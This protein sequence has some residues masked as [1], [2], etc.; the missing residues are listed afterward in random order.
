MRRRVTCHPPTHSRSNSVVAPAS[1]PPAWLS[2][3]GLPGA[4]RGHRDWRLLDTAFGDGERFLQLWRAWSQDSQACHHLHVVAFSDSVPTADALVRAASADPT[5]TSLVQ[6]L[7][8]Q[9]FGLMPGFH[10][11]VLAQG[12]L[13]LTLC[14]GPTLALLRQQQFLAD[15]I[16]LSAPVSAALPDDT[17]TPT[18]WD[19][20]ALK[21]LTRLCRRASTL[22]VL[23]QAGLDIRLLPPSLWQ[24]RLGAPADPAHPVWSGEYQPGWQIKS[25][26]TAWARPQ[27]SDSHCVVIGAGLAGAAV[28]DALAQRG[29]R[30]TVLDS[31]P[32]PAAG[33]SS[34]PVG[35]FAPQI[36][37][38]DGPRSRL[39]RAGI[40]M[41]LLAA[42]RL[43]QQGRDWELSGVLHVRDTPG[44]ALPADWPASG[45]PWA[46]PSTPEH[47]NGSSPSADSDRSLWHATAGWIK[48]AQLVQ[49]WLA[50]PSVRFLGHSTV[51][52]ISLECG[53]WHV[54][55]R[56]G[57][58]LVQAPQLVIA[59]A[60]N[61][62]A[63]AH[64][65]LAAAGQA[66]P[67]PLSSL[68]PTPGRVSWAMH[69]AADAAC[70]PNTPINGS[71]SVVA[72][73]PYA[74][75]T[76][77]FAGATYETLTA[78]PLT[79]AMAHAQNLARMHSLAPRAAH[80]V[81]PAF[82]CGA[83]HAWCATRWS[84][85][86][87]LPI[88][89]AW[90]LHLESA[91]PG[92]WI[93]TAMGSR[94]LTYAALCGELIAAQMG[95]EPLPLEPALLAAISIRRLRARELRQRS[96]GPST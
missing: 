69:G 73:V 71:G 76:A 74:D 58:L 75:G 3:A 66:V 94:G 24:P 45:A 52:A 7:E 70:F 37:R 4:W 30:V 91:A 28:A 18:P 41:T 62:L 95:A 10:R 32:A 5:C 14:V 11:L 47:A 43:L 31:A 15:T 20:W 78:S 50:Q 39:S 40:R 90:P 84:S 83:V 63:L 22:T 9:W 23:P 53:Q 79:E 85:A 96:P 77:W 93:S 86:D 56:D 19:T 29:R 16:V 17:H 87:R 44:P 13:R 67:T 80:A 25:T 60:G 55:A 27:A 89:G 59:C 54:L 64:L 49:A 46:R 21:S 2:A 68:I 1:L 33:A 12:R 34:L 81:G 57:T 8:P 72:H 61:S 65:A 82:A 36:S 48:P 26:R 88:V 92:L 51:H 38:D 6:E 35:L 42:R